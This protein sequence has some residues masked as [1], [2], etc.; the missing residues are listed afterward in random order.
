MAQEPISGLQDTTPLLCSF[1]EYVH[2]LKHTCACTHTYAYSPY[3]QVF[4]RQTLEVYNKDPYQKSS[5]QQILNM[6]HRMSGPFPCYLTHSFILLS[7]PLLHYSYCLHVCHLSRLRTQQN[8]GL[9][10][11][12]IFLSQTLCLM[13]RTQQILQQV[14]LQTG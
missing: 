10:V 12:Y 1:Q 11:L 13:P 9:Y 5:S 7:L 6:L 8:Y 3:T 4:I 14:W 2:I